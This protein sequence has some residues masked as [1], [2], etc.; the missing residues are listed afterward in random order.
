MENKAISIPTIVLACTAVVISIWQ[1]CETRRHNKLSVKP[2]LSITISTSEN[3]SLMGVWIDNNGTGP[4]IIKEFFV[5]LDGQPTKVDSR[6]TANKVYRDAG[7]NISAIKFGCPVPSVSLRHGGQFNI[8]S[9]PKNNWTTKGKEEFKK[10]LSHLSFTF[11]YE[12][13]YKEKFVTSTF[14]K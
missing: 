14:E 5:H 6:E 11:I 10:R 8:I 1:G 4:A 13:I 7:I 9:Y 12:S 3:D 2:L